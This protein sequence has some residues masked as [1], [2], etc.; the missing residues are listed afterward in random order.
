MTNRRYLV[1]I[2]WYPSTASGQVAVNYGG[3]TSSVPTYSGGYF[4]S[5]MP[6]V[7]L[8]ATGSTY[9]EALNNLLLAASAS[10]Y[11]GGYPPRY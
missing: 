2:S 6:E 5:A 4:V 3:V 11:D 8:S 1:N 9:T 7:R 10:T